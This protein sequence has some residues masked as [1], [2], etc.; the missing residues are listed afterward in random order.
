MLSARHEHVHEHVHE[1]D[2][3]RRLVDARRARRRGVPGQRAD[4]RHGDLGR[5]VLHHHLGERRVLHRGE[6]RVLH[7]GERR[8]RRRVQRIAPGGAPVVAGSFSGTLDLGT[9]T[10]VAQGEN[11]T[12]VAALAP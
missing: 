11:D 8:Q 10:L 9:E 7:R 12:F 6:R 5:D 2:R 1:D 3:R 4:Q